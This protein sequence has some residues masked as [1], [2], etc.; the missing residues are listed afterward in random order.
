MSE[1]P[2]GRRG[3]GPDCE[4]ELP[5]FVLVSPTLQGGK[6]ALPPA[7]YHGPA[8]CGLKESPDGWVHSGLTDR[9]FR[10]DCHACRELA[11]EMLSGLSEEEG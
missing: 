4:Q 2:S 7:T 9:L 11:A 10:I 1:G 3:G 5:K 8:L 6:H